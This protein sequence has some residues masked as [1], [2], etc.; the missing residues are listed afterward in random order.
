VGGTVAVDT[1]LPVRRVTPGARLLAAAPAFLPAVM[2]AIA[3]WQYRWLDEDA[4]INLRIVDQ[5]FAG[6]GPV[7]NAGERVEASTSPM[8]IGVLVAGRALFSWLATM[9]WITLL[10]SLAAA[11]GAFAVAG[12]ATRVRHRD[13]PKDANDPVVVP[14]GLYLVAAVA[15]VWEFST[16]GLETGLTWLWIAAAWLALVTVARTPDFAGPRRNLA[17]VTLGLAPLVRPDLGVMMVSFLV[18]WFVLARPRRIVFDLTFVFALPVAYQVFRMGYYASVVPNTALAK[19]AG[20]LYLDQ[21]WHY[22]RDFSEPYH[23]WFALLVI[24]VVVVVNLSAERDHRLLIGSVAMLTAAILHAAYIVAIG[25]DYMHG[26][27]LLPAFFAVALPASLVLR[28][29]APAALAIAGVAAVWVLVSMATLR[30]PTPEA[31][32]GFGP[33][34]IADW[35]LLSDAP[36]E[37]DEVPSPITVNGEQAAALAEDG[38]TGY[39]KVLDPTRYPGEDPDLLVVTFGSIGVAGYN[40]GPDV[41]VVD[42]GGLAE[43][44][45]ARS[46][47]ISGRQAGHRKEIDHAWYDARFGVVTGDDPAAAAAARALECAPAR[48]LLAALT[49]DLTPGR[50][51]SNLWHSARFTRMHVPADPENAAAEWCDD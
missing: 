50:F 51:L 26:R 41:H 43:P 44:L 1:D 25:G 35:R 15:V 42:I 38:V 34:A 46:D 10:A 18:A 4:F 24:V 6:N 33:P 23:L 19:D 16:S 45:A 48:D 3:G 8:W 5:V 11:V 30:P 13:S 27:L 32:D 29:R 37:P 31:M 17:C 49:D 28:P 20:G 14:V 22:A 39:Y 9:E 21:G 12:H 47:A 36:F 7:F 2:I 40:A